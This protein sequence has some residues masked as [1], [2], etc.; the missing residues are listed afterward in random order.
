MHCTVKQNDQHVHFL[1]GLLACDFIKFSFYS[2]SVM[3][4]ATEIQMSIYFDSV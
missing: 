1:S 2:I 3:L 4:F